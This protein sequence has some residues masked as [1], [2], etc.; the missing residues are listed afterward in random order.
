MQAIQTQIVR[1]IQCKSNKTLNKYA[2]IACA[3][4]RKNAS[5]FEYNKYTQILL[6]MTESMRLLVL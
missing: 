2:G 5:V 3:V 1:I 6:N 4:K